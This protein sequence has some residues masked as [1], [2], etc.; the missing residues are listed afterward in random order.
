[1]VENCMRHLTHDASAGNGQRRSR[2]EVIRDAAIEVRKPTMF[3]ELIIII[4]FLPILTL[5]G[6]EG[7][8]FRPMALTFI[9]ALVG[10]LVLSL[11]LMP[12]LASLALPRRVSERDPMLIR[13]ARAMYEPAL[14]FAMRQRFAVIVLAL[15]VLGLAALV[16]RGMGSEFVPRLLEG[17]LVE[18]TVRLA[19]TDLDASVRYNTELEKVILAKFPDE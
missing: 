13:A 14:R 10:S 3:G 8:M 17:S 2:L 19:G 7:K 9:F 15:A 1:M 12:V 6:I 16:A 5:E 11:T 4:V 18:N